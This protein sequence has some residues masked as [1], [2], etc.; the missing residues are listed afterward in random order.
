MQE[1]LRPHVLSERECCDVSGGSF[2]AVGRWAIGAIGGGLLYD[3]V[4]SAVNSARTRWNAL[5]ATIIAS[6]YKNP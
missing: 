3:G 4:K 6:H 2:I 1:V 5:P